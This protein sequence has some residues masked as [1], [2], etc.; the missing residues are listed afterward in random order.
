MDEVLDGEC[1]ARDGAK[2][3]GKPPDGGSPEDARGHTAR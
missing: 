3:E 2:P 1:K